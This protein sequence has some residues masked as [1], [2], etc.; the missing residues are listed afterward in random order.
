MCDSDTCSTS[1]PN[2][3]IW[4]DS[5]SAFVTDTIGAS[6]DTDGLCLAEPLSIGLRDGVVV[7]K[8]DMCTR[9]AFVIDVWD[10]VESDPQISCAAVPDKD[11]DTF[12]GV[13]FSQSFG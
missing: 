5:S 8:H 10:L 7:G 4:R 1:H 6:E 12:C 2:K 13:I 9:W 3:S 11:G